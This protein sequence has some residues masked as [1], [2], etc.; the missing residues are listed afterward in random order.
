MFFAYD[1]GIRVDLITDYFEVY[2]P[3]YSNRGWEIN[4]SN[5][6]QRIRFVFTTDFSALASLFTRKWF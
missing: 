2:F 3:M 4:Q 1:T 5:Y 6:A